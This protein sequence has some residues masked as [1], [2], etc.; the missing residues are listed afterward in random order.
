LPARS[1]RLLGGGKRK[2]ADDEGENIAPT[3]KRRPSKKSPKPK[4]SD[5]QT[6]AKERTL[7]SMDDDE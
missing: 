2:A 1:N 3:P 7:F 4:S 5:P 6:V